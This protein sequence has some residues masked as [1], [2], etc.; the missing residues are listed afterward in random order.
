[1]IQNVNNI[2]VNL[3]TI[4]NND[5]VLNINNIIQLYSC[6]SEYKFK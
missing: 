4:I 2:I 1:M 3:D 6:K 5:Y